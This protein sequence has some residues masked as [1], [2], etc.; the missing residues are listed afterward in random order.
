MKI[1]CDSILVLYDEILLQKQDKL[2]YTMITTKGYEVDSIFEE[3][4]VL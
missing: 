4:H 2:I 1:Q 3:K